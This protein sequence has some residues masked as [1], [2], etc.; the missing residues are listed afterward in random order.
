LKRNG[1]FEIRW[2][3]QVQA[4]AEKSDRLPWGFTTE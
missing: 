2:P 1:W 3:V 4:V